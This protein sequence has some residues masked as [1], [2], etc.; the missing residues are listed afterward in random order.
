VSAPWLIKKPTVSSQWDDEFEANELDSRWTKLIPGGADFTSVS[1]FDPYAAFTTGNHRYSINK[2]R[3]SWL[4]IQPVANYGVGG[5]SLNQGWKMDISGLPTNCFI[6]M[7]ASASERRASMTD[8][9]GEVAIRLFDPLI[10]SMITCMID[11]FASIREGLFARSAPSVP[12]A[13]LGLI[14]NYFG[15]GFP[16]E[17]IGVQ[18]RGLTWDGW[19]APA[20]GNWVWMGSYTHLVA[21]TELWLCFN[22][23]T[24]GS[25]GNMILGADFVR[26]ISGKGPP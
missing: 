18:K 6:Y 12:Y 8:G 23:Q 16:I 3:K 26:V 21:L 17:Y 1:T 15:E 7:R 13:N 11:G 22:N 10:T 20:S 14:R 4:M 19:V 24:S 2:H 9:D 25:P 5:N